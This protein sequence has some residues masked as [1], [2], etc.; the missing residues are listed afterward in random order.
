MFSKKIKPLAGQMGG[1]NLNLDIFP[2]LLAIGNPWAGQT[3]GINIASLPMAQQAGGDKHCFRKVSNI[4][5]IL[6]PGVGATQ[7]SSYRHCP[8]DGN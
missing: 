3:G 6:L 7:L 5:E 1:D 2:M 8:V 4:F